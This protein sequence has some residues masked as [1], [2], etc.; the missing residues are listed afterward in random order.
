MKSNMD[1]CLCGGRGLDMIVVSAGIGGAGGGG[2]WKGSFASPSFLLVQ[3][4]CTGCHGDFW[5]F[6]TRTLFCAGAGVL[7]F[8]SPVRVVLSIV[9]CPYGGNIITGVTSLF[10]TVVGEGK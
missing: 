10:L 4:L 5:V 3:L 2:M 9:F 1:R 6:C 8:G 7:L